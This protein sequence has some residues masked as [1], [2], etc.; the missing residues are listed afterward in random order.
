VFANAVN[1]VRIRFDRAIEIAR[2]GLRPK[3][4]EARKRGDPIM[5]AATMCG[6]PRRPAHLEPSN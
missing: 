4:P 1:S 5:A 6:D 2:Y 3:R